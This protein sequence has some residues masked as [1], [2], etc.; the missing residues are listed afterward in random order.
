MAVEV[1]TFELSQR[2]NPVGSHTLRTELRG[3]TVHLE[4]RMQ[5]EGALGRGT[6]TQSS[7]SHARL[8][9]SLSFRE[10]QQRRGDNRVYDVQFD[11][12]S[13]LVKASRGGKDRAEQ[14]LSRPYRD[15]LGML[16]EIRNLDPAASLV[17]IPM[18]GKDVQVSLVGT[19]LL[20]TPLGEREARVY[21]L[22]PGGSLVWVDED[23]PN[24]IL[25][26]QQ[27]TAS[28]PVDA[29]LSRIGS[30]QG[31]HREPGGRQEAQA[32]PAREGGS[33]NRRSRS[34]RGRRR[35]SSKRQD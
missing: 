8:H 28:L 25:K 15:P 9:H 23:E 31:S 29:V 27:R 35:R 18:V 24:L 1:L 19:V 12:A 32:R 22:F 16:F 11:R 33:G 17:S 3:G 4:G 30:E 14:P 10:E 21:R 26:M 20:D 34:R 13:G 2:G 7:R 5:F 6:I